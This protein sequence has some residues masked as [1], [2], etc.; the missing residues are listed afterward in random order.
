MISKNEI[1]HIQ[2]LFHKKQR[3]EQGLF[4]IEGKK[5]AAEILKSDY[6]IK[7]IYALENWVI[8]NDVKHIETTI[9]TA[10]EL[11]KISQLSTPNE[12]LMI[13]EIPRDVTTKTY[14]NQ[15]SIILDDIQDPGNFGSI[16]R[17]ADWFA[18]PQIICSKETVD[19]YNSKVIQST[20][21]SFLRV[22]IVYENLE[23]FLQAN[24]LPVYGALLDGEN[25]MTTDLQKNGYLI[26]GNEGK[27]ISNAILPF[28]TNAITIPKFGG[29]ESLNAAIAT[30]IIVSHFR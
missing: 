26:I 29:A 27:G 8:A 15:L 20:M 25:M 23:V 2:S 1:K 13:I 19:L 3:L 6:K 28:I 12:V 17:I 30:G 18:I 24:K 10:D 5:L 4:L 14:T 21:G 22:N 7:K 11:N 9:L 16:I